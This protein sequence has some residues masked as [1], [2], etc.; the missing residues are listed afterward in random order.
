MRDSP[1]PRYLALVG[2]LIVTFAAAGIG[3]AATFPSV[4]TWYPT[5]AKPSWTPPSWLFGPVWTT[6]YVAM[7]VAAWRVWRGLHGAPAAT[8]VVVLFGTQIALNALWSILF[9]G[10]RRPGL[11]LVDIVALWVLLVVILVRF[12]RADR[13]SGLLWTPYVAWV[14]FATAL[15]AAIWNLNC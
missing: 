12:W 13:I 8:A 10:M 9:F 11:A 3:S 2:F 6:L 15:N 4:H 1:P 14:S 7:A 5:L